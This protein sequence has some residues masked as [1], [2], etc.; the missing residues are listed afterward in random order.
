MAAPITLRDLE[1]ARARTEAQLNTRGLSLRDYDP[2]AFSAYAPPAAPTELRQS[3]LAQLAAERA[4]A[5]RTL[6][7]GAEPIYADTWS[8]GQGVGENLQRGAAQ[9]WRGLRAAGHAAL[10]GIAEGLGA[11]EFAQNRFADAQHWAQK[12]AEVAPRVQSY[13]DV[14]NLQDAVDYGAGV[15]GNLTGSLPMLAAGAVA[16]RATRGRSPLLQRAGHVMFAAA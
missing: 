4:P 13:K 9:G 6:P 10:G 11:D 16:A 8:S 7:E 14:N 1:A 2:V 5:Q 3:A 15:V 12:A